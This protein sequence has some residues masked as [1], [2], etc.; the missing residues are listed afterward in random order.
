MIININ[1]AFAYVITYDLNGG[2]LPTGETEFSI[3]STNDEI[4]LANPIRTGHTFAGWCEKN[5]YESD[6]VCDSPKCIEND[7]A[8]W[9][10]PCTDDTIQDD[11]DYIALWRLDGCPNVVLADAQHNYTMSNGYKDYGAMN[12]SLYRFTYDFNND[13][14]TTADECMT[15]VVKVEHPEYLIENAT[16][17]DLSAANILGVGFCRYDGTNYNNCVAP[18]GVCKAPLLTSYIANG[19]TGSVMFDYFRSQRSTVRFKWSADSL[20][21][22]GCIHCPQAVSIFGDGAQIS[23]ADGWYAVSQA[24]TDMDDNGETSS[25]CLSMVVRSNNP[26]ALQSGDYANAEVTG[27]SICR[28]NIQTQ[29]YDKCSLA[30]MP[31][32]LA[33]WQFILQA[34]NEMWTYDDREAAN[35]IHESLAR[36]M[37]NSSNAKLRDVDFIYPS[38]DIPDS[39]NCSANPLD[40]V[41]MSDVWLPVINEQMCL[42]DID[43]NTTV[44]ELALIARK[45]SSKYYV[46][47][48]EKT[49]LDNPVPIHKNSTINVKIKAFDKTQN[50]N[51]LYYVHD[52]SVSDE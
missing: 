50:K 28:Y 20:H 49:D 7:V 25:E 26:T 45:N 32:S 40:F 42:I 22:A 51:T 17:E 43:V 48:V 44:P 46:N 19:D 52:A 23:L 8:T 39:N 18:I 29:M 13:G 5:D 12:P 21:T 31:C 24:P 37:M 35:E 38:D 11:T 14:E 15:M 41:C 16:V 4:V 36:L 34:A 1:S 10:I 6:G 9:T 3:E 33:D 2:A 27:I 47:L 30:V